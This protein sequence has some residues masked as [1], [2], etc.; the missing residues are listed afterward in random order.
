[1]AFVI[2]K[3]SIFYSLVFAFSCVT[4]QGS[5]QFEKDKARSRVL[6]ID[7]LSLNADLSF[8]PQEGLVKGE[9]NIEFKNISNNLDSI[10]FDAIKMKV[11]QAYLNRKTVSYKVFEKGIAFFPDSALAK[12]SVY[13][14]A[15]AFEASPKRGMYFL[16][17]NDTLDIERKQIWTQGQGIDNRHW[18]PLVDAKNDKL[19]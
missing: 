16:G 10:W 14:L 6:Q 2:K 12:D 11:G 4:F 15:L 19:I 1:M 17:W 13:K 3:S 9:V 18:L 8:E 7:Q 5:A